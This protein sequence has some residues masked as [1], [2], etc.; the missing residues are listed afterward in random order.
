MLVTPIDKTI[1]TTVAKPS[2]IAATAKL[3]AIINVL[4]TT[5]PS[6]SPAR[7]KLNANI[8]AQIPKTA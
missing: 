2:G 7:N 3:T 5:L 6:I 8:N 1:V 4:K